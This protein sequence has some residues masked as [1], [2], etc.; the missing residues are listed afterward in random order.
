MCFSK[1][2]IFLNREHDAST[3]IVG[4]EVSVAQTIPPKTKRFVTVGHCST[5]C[6][7]ASLPKTGINVFNILLHSHNAGTPPV[8]C[9][10]S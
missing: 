10:I 5:H 6:T 8:Q 9:L 3:L 2:Y 1:L 4:H 7:E